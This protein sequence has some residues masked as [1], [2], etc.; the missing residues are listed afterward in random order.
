MIYSTGIVYKIVCT[1]DSGIVYIGSTFNLL[2]QRW[3]EHK[4]QYKRYLEGEYLGVSIFPYFTKYGIEN[5]KILKIKE[6][7]CCRND[8]RDAKHLHVFEQLWINKT[9]GCVNKYN[10]FSI[11]I[12]A[13][14]KYKEREK[15]YYQNNKEQKKEYYQNNSERILKYQKEYYENNSERMKDRNKEY[16]QNNKER[17]SEYYQNNKEQKKEYYQKNKERKKERSKEYYEK[18]KGEKVEC[19]ICKLTIKKT[20]LYLHKKSKKHIKNLEKN[21]V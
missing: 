18:H 9:K 10:A 4:Q 13:K 8:M 5:F 6:Y 14:E 19:D 12:V 16:Y 17:I 11:P 2:R 15:E 3:Q 21:I 7:K 1:L 20:S